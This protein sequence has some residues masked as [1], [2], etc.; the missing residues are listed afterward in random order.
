M[1]MKKVLLLLS[2]GLDSTILLAHL[3]DAGYE[4]T[5]ISYD[6]GQRHAERELAAATAIAGHFGVDNRRVP[7]AS[8]F[9]GC[10]LLGEGE[11]PEGHA[12]EPDATVVP[13]RN[14]VFLAV[15]VSLAEE[16]GAA[17]VQIG[18]IQDD[19]A[20]YLDCRWEFI[21]ALDYAVGW[22]THIPGIRIEAPFIEMSKVEVLQR[23][24]ALDAP[25]S[26][27]WSCYRGQAEPCGQC[28]ACQLL[29]EAYAALP[30]EVQQ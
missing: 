12:T 8:V 4:V 21:D 11:I 6:Y 26:L 27:T 13:G 16:L 10:A 14:L 5:T 23:G 2:G 18:A 9:A 29:Q 20:A 1:S 15:G 22:S 17:T 24:V 30:Q 25:L 19:A 3:V 28:G 7:L